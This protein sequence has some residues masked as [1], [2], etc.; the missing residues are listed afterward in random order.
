[1]DRYDEHSN[2]YQCEEDADRGAFTP[3]AAEAKKNGPDVAADDD[4]PGEPDQRLRQMH[5]LGRNDGQHPF[6]SVDGEDAEACLGTK[7]DKGVPRADITVTQLPDILV[8]QP[9]PGE[10]GRGNAAQE[11][12]KDDN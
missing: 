8:L 12:S 7:F 11:I 2:W 5:S 4:D 3:P 9:V 6:G 10:V 1:M